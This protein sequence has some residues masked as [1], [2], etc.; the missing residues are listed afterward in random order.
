MF[1]TSVGTWISEDKDISLIPAALMA[2]NAAAGETVTLSAL[3]IASGTKGS[4]DWGDGTKENFSNE[5]TKSSITNGKITLNHQYIAAFTGEAKIFVQEGKIS[6]EVKATE[7]DKIVINDETKVSVKKPFVFTVNNSGKTVKFSPGNLYW[8][9]SSF[10]FEEHQ[11]DY[12]TSWN[13]NHIGYFFWS[14]DASIA[15]AASYNDSGNTT[16]DKFFAADGGAIGGWTVLDNEELQYLIDNALEKISNKP[17]IVTVNSKKCVVLKPDGFSG[18]VINTYTAI[19]W[20]AAESTYGLV[21]L[22]LAGGQFSRNN[23]DFRD[24][25]NIGYYWSTTP[26]FDN[27]GDAY[28]ILFN[29]N[30]AAV[31]PLNRYIAYPVRLV[32]V[33]D[34]GE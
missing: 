17:K 22:P 6:G 11:Y 28:S 23:S 3:N 20:T 4:V 10:A 13:T 7:Y 26:S 27:T 2:V 5:G 32:Q 25:G 33:I 18:T 24:V 31:G 12:P 34:E 9:G 19:D 21:A 29:S 1:V 16:A 15:Y 14:K 30:A 8:N